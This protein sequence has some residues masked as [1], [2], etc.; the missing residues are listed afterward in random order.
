M[1][2][3]LI[4]Q[5][6]IPVT[7][8]GGVEKHVEN[9]AV[10]LVELGHEVIVY[11]RHSYTDKRLKEY[12]GVKLVGLPSVPTKNLDAISHTFLAVIAVIFRKVD[13]VH[14]HSIGPSSLIWLVK[15]F[16]PHTP[17]VATFHSQCYHNQK[18]GLFAK[19]Y[20]R[21][22]EY[23]CSRKADTVITVSKSLLDHVL[24]KYPQAHARYIPNGVNVLPQL[25][26]QEITDK[27]GLTKDSYILNVGRLVANKGVE[28]LI[29]AY[30][31]I[32]TDKKL[33]IVGDGVMEADLKGLADND[34]NIIFTGN[35][36]GQILG[37]LFSN[38][39]LFVQPSESEGLS[40]ALLEAMSYQNPCL[41]SDIPANCE[42][43]GLDGLT[44]K[45]MDTANLK[46]K[47]EELLTS[48]DKLKA[49]K[50][51][52]Y[53]KVVQEYDWTKIVNSI[54]DIYTQAKAKK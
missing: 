10:R 6:G 12:K 34:P 30:H 36:N 40:L 46:T 27:W 51:E 21:F 43:V 39:Y 20:L 8:G 45:N 4:G 16:K 24:K 23:M 22:G 50:E 9:L 28:Y 14:F 17:V 19:N 31:Q 11:T 37:E 32:K 29:N 25:S 26:A 18:W 33:V 49:N 54:V 48:P 5:K 3:A 47:L 42:V 2:I 38:A 53:N 7:H 1:K 35:Q 13:V 15:L 44:F 52:M 41:V